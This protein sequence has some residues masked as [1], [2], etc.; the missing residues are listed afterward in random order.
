MSYVQGT[1]VRVTGQ[2]TDEETGLAFDP[3]EVI[4]TVE[5]PDG[6]TFE[7]RKTTGDVHQAQNALSAPIPGSYYTDIDTAPAAGIWAYQFASTGANKVV[8]RKNI[9]VRQQVPAPAV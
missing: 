7:L 4:V 1:V 3:A 8:S 2:F 9:T 5:R 6:T